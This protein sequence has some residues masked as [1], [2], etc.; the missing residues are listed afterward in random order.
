MDLL[1][2]HLAASGGGADLDPNNILGFGENNSAG[3]NLGHQIVHGSSSMGDLVFLLL[4][5]FRKSFR[6]SLRQEDGIVSEAQGA[7][8]GVDYGSLNRAGGLNQKTL[9]TQGKRGDKFRVSRCPRTALQL[10]E[11]EL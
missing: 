8:R 2:G 3:F 6:A 9:D 7:T 10:A 1:S 5:H 4:R 11:E